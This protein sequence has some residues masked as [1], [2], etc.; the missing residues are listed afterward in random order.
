MIFTSAQIEAVK[1][2][3]PVRFCTSEIGVECVVVR[4]D[5]YERVQSVVEDG[6]PMQQVGQL[7]QAAM[8]EDDE[9]D[10]LLD[11]YQQYRQ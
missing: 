11:S 5:V 9:N 4:A 2:G 10:P 8:R 7:V 1:H 6:L 3:K